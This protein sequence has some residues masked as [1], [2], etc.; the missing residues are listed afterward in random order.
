MMACTLLSQVFRGQEI[1][2][3]SNQPGQASPQKNTNGT[4]YLGLSVLLTKLTLRFPEAY[5]HP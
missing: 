2:D 5:N 4:P 1:Q 3:V